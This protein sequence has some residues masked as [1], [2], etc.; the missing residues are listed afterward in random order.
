MPDKEKD[1]TCFFIEIKNL[2]DKKVRNIIVRN[3]M[4]KVTI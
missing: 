4:I 3:L 2:T 1:R